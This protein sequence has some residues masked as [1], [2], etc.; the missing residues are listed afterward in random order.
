MKRHFSDFGADLYFDGSASENEIL[1]VDLDTSLAPEQIVSIVQDCLRLAKQTHPLAHRLPLQP[2]LC[3]VHRDFQP[4][5][6]R[7]SK[8]ASDKR[9]P[10]DNV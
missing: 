2:N 5:C 10:A 1:A 3:K 7:I 8:G 4:V 9:F 6:D